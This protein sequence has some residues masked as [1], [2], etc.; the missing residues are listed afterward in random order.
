M[1]LAHGIAISEPIA[2]VIIFE[3]NARKLSENHLS[4]G[5]IHNTAPSSPHHLIMRPMPTPFQS[6]MNHQQWMRLCIDE[7]RLALPQDVPV[8]AIII[9]DGQVIAQAH[10]RREIAHNPT[11]HAEIL[12]LTEAGK[13]LGDWR[14][15]GCTLYVTLEPCPMCAAA[16][17][18]AR[19]SSIVF[20]A[21][22]PL[23]GACGSKQQLTQIN[24]QTE[25]IG[26]ILEQECQELLHQFFQARR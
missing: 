15:T 2:I 23:Q 26:G 25:A 22:D 20:G 1:P 17:D 3:Q 7:A 4:E 21:Y 24:H 9:K 13:K 16:I 12:A 8:G 6:P 10:N 5:V 18:Q 14:L 11:A 19:V